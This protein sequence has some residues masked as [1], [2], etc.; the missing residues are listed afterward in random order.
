MQKLFFFKWYAVFEVT[1][2]QKITVSTLSTELPN[3][4][5]RKQ[6]GLTLISNTVSITK[7]TLGVGVGVGMG[8]GPGVAAQRD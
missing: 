4:M 5:K 1:V 6:I 2:S 8:R 3:Q 7:H